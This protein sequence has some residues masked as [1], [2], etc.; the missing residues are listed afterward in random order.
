VPE[1][2]HVAPVGWLEAGKTLVLERPQSFSPDHVQA[3]D[4]LFHDG[5]TPWGKSMI[6]AESVQLLLG[7]EMLIDAGL[8]RGPGD[9]DGELAVNA[10]GQTA[11]A[12]ARNRIVELVFELIRRLEYPDKPSRMTCV[13]AYRTVREAL[14]YREHRR[15][16]MAHE[17]WRVSCPDGIP[18]HIGDGRWLGVP[19]DSLL[20]VAAARHYWES[21]PHPFP[22]TEFDVEVIVPACEVTV[23]AVEV[24]AAS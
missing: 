16:P 3:L 10:A 11:M 13:F 21:H 14:D 9:P 2:F 15:D 6:T 12:D 23:V 5:L 20:F 1:L 4:S 24:P 22:N 17:V 19:R 8:A 7:P 18:A